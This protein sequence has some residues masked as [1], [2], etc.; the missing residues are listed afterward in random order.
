M[1]NIFH[2]GGYSAMGM[3]DKLIEKFFTA[4]KYEETITEIEAFRKSKK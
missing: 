3:S 4:E 2:D 1:Q